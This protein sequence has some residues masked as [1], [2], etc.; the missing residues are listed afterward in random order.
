MYV[1]SEKKWKSLHQDNARPDIK[2]DG[3]R[4]ED[5][6]RPNKIK[7]CRKSNPSASILIIPSD[8]MLSSTRGVITFNLYEFKAFN[9]IEKIEVRLDRRS[10]KFQLKENL[11]EEFRRKSTSLF[12]KREMNISWKIKMLSCRVNYVSN[13]GMFCTCY[14]L[15]LYTVLILFKWCLILHYSFKY[16]FKF[17]IM[18]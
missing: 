17:L 5:G 13:Y 6:F 9:I 10:V 11:N 7:V 14:S 1:A 15:S 12:R 16:F 8:R 4:L 2:F 18:L 3:A